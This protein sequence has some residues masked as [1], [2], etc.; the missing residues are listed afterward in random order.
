MSNLV[1][2]GA[3]GHTRATVSTAKLM[4]KW[5]NLTILDINFKGGQ[6]YILGVKVQ[7]YNEFIKNFNSQNNTF[8]ISVGDNLMRKKYILI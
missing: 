3:G 4:K 1:I 8:F 7:D 2:V 5:N 6:E